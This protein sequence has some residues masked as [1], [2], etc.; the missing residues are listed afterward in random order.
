MIKHCIIVKWNEKVT[1]K[2]AFI[3][4]IKRIFD[5]TLSLSGVEKVELFRSVT[6]RPNRYDLM[7]AVTMEQS[8]LPDYD[9]SAPHA[10]WKKTYSPF[11]E[12][13]A[14]FDFEI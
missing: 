6:D 7:I 1:D 11:I 12:S 14:I 2:A 4:D 10:E 3:P 5:G 8:T 13:K 9:A